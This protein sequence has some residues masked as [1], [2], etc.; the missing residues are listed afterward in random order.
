MIPKIIHQIWVGPLPAPRR[1][2]NTWKRKHRDYQYMFW[3]EKKLNQTTLLH[4][5][6]PKINE[7]EEICG[8]VDIIRLVL[9]YEFGGI[10]LDA[11]S[12]CLE[13]IP[14]EF[15]NNKCFVT[16]E[17]EKI[18]QGLLS[19]GNMGFIPKHPIIKE[20]LDHILKN[21]ISIRETKVQAWQNTGPLL[22]TNTIVKMKP[23]DL[24]IYPSYYFL[25]IHLDGLV[26]KGH[27]KIY[28][29]Q[30]WGS[31]KDNINELETIE[32]PETINKI[33]E[34]K[35]S[36]LI[37]TYNTSA[38]YLKECFESIIQQEG[39]FFMEIVIINDASDKLHSSILEKMI[40]KY[41]NL[42]RFCEWKLYTLDSNIGVAGALQHGLEKCSH[43]II[44]RMDSDDIM[45]AERIEK[46]LDYMNKNKDC[47]IVGSQMIM[48]KDHEDKKL[49][50]GQ[51]NHNSMTIQQFA[52]KPSD[53]FINHPTVMFKKDE[54][55]KLGGYNSQHKG[56]PEDFNLWLRILKSGNK[57]H[58]MNEI[59]LYYRLH[60]KQASHEKIR[61]KNKWLQEKN[62]W[63]DE[64]LRH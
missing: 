16:F 62:K 61:Q 60:E 20:M 2:M 58:N 47:I 11:D 49:N 27:G 19:N 64:I 21:P 25:P 63:I 18:R 3:D 54:I 40:D 22:L 33:P 23:K 43:N 31:S 59:L 38:N 10:Y 48:F 57:I 30:E 26:Y 37:P 50:V 34:T 35:I 4:K 52:Q 53:W 39:D 8:K 56:L 42:S 44:V 17:N 46:Q 28:A 29:Y 12:I 24:K 32:I 13:K 55:I 45:I 14:D 1:M 5:M 6:M 36:L 7:I 41:K 15:L 9:L 51:T